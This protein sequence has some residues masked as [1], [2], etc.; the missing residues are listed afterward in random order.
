[1][2]DRLNRCAQLKPAMYVRGVEQILIDGM[3]NTEIA[4]SI[5]RKIADFYAEYARR[6]LQAAEGN[7]DIFFTGDDGTTKLDHEL[8][9]YSA[10]DLI[11]WVR[12]PSLSS[13]VDTVVYM[14]YGNATP[15]ANL[16]AAGVW[17]ANYVIV[18]HL[19]ENS[20][21]HFDATGYLNDSISNT[22]CYR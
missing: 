13:S 22:N 17:D 4:K 18:Q 10:G 14:Y 3:L 7:V 9:T 2:G 21:T 16:D 11:A 20:G 15:P 6:T 12:V 8:V 19:D 1:M 5:F